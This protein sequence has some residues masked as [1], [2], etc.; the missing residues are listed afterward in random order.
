MSLQA[1]LVS[2]YPLYL[3]QFH[4]S[5]LIHLHAH[6]QVLSH[7]Q[8][9]TEGEPYSASLPDARLGGLLHG[10]ASLSEQEPRA[11]RSGLQTLHLRPRALAGACPVPLWLLAL[12]LA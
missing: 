11:L 8:S 4:I 10:R 12:L 2:F 3:V 5:C 7:S 6:L 1:L 9:R